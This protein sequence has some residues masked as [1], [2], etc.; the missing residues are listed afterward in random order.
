MSRT[1]GVWALLVVALT[2]PLMAQGFYTVAQADLEEEIRPLVGDISAANFYDYDDATRRSQN[3]LLVEEQNSFLF[4]YE[5]PDGQVFMFIIHGPNAADVFEVEAE[6]RIADVP[7]GADWIV[8]DNPPDVRPFNVYDLE[9]ERAHWTWGGWFRHYQTTAGGVLGPLGEEFAIAVTPEFFPGTQN[10]YVLTG[11]ADAPNRIQL[12]RQDTITL[13]GSVDPVE[14]VDPDAPVARFALEPVAPRLREEVKF[15][16]TDSEHDPDLFIEEYYWEFG[17]GTE[18]S[19]TE[20]Q[21]YHT[22]TEEGVY[23]VTLTVIDSAGRQSEVATQE[24]EV[25]DVVISAVRSISTEEVTP[26][27]TFRVK[28]RLLADQDLS[29]AGLKEN[30]PAGWKVTPIDSAGAVYRQASTEWVFQHTIRGTT[31]PVITYDVTAP[32]RDDLRARTLPFSVYIEGTF[33]AKSPDF[34]VEVE[35]ESLVTVTDCLS[36]K[37]AIT[38]MVPR[39]GENDTD[40]IDLRMSEVITGPQIQRATEL[41]KKSEPVV[42]TCGERIDLSMMKRL[43]AY[44]EACVPV[45]QPLPEDLPMPDLTAERTI[46]TPIPCTQVILGY[47][48]DNGVPIGN[49]FTVEVRISTDVDAMAV[50]LDERLPTGWKVIPVDNDGFLYNPQEKQWVL[51]DTMKG[52]TSRTI[53]YEVEV[54]TDTA[55]EAPPQEPGCVLAVENLRGWADTGWPCVEVVVQ[56]DTRVE[57]TDCLDIIV[58]ISRWDPQKEQIDLRRSDKITFDQLQAAVAFWLEGEPVPHACAPG[59][60]D[61]ETLKLLTSMWQTGTPVCK[62]LPQTPPGV[63]D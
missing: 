2:L 26:G 21:V 18:A 63:C 1:F 46:M 40:T 22:Y 9:G 49:K 54:P 61:Y 8:Q 32:E 14:V 53:V 19:T 27:A 11:D 24:I 47:Q 34:E 36:I 56:G 25:R 6:F 17:D 15:D 13:F 7:P 31:E 29:G 44:H 45:D 41:W 43:I 51:L 48:D 58:A 60:L 59:I 3:Q 55:V 52:G 10:L 50:G 57:L 4:L 35:G 33:Q 30:L 12:N 62:E 28:V 16:A 38:H 42:G 37:T 39:S 23:E 5:D 20:P